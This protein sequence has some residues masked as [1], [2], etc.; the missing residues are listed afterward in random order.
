MLV[1][2][3]IHYGDASQTLAEHLWHCLAARGSALLSC[4]CSV[5]DTVVAEAGGGG[6]RYTQKQ[7]ST[8]TGARWSDGCQA[9]AESVCVKKALSAGGDGWFS[10]GGAGSKRFALSGHALW[11]GF[12]IKKKLRPVWERTLLDVAASSVSTVSA[13]LAMALAGLGCCAHGVY[14]CAVLSA[15][16]SWEEWFLP[17]L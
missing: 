7:V 9:F 1:G 2:T 16:G 15:R 10:R 8:N 13:L 17:H 3:A 11:G 14:V 6:E 4:S 5:T 12:S